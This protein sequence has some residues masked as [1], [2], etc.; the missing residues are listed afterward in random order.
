MLYGESLL[1]TDL[2]CAV[3]HNLPIPEWNLLP[4]LPEPPWGGKDGECLCLNYPFDYTQ[5]LDPFTMKAFKLISQ[6]EF[7]GWFFHH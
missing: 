4:P 1:Q 6:M 3:I 5:P 2:L 7:G